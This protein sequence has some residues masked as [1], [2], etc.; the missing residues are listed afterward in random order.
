MM[1]TCCVMMENGIFREYVVSALE[2]T[3]IRCV[4]EPAGVP[5][6]CCDEWIPD[7]P[8]GSQVLVLYRRPRYTRSPAYAAL[9][10]R[11]ECRAMERPF[12]LEELVQ[13]VLEMTGGREHIP[14]VI[15]AP[16]KA[17]NAVTLIRDTLTA[18]GADFTVHLTEREFRVLEVLAE[19]AGETVSRELLLRDAWDGMESRGNVVDVYV[20]Y[21][22]KKLE[23]HFG[24]GVILSIRGKGYVLSPG[25]RRIVLK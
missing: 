19:R 25:E 13:T 23:P 24:K 20:G 16:E 14:A 17:D 4:N 18:E 21:L 8:D 22:R 6:I 2:L 3:G 11:C 5:V 9:S 15:N 7:I 12:L 1:G 10:E